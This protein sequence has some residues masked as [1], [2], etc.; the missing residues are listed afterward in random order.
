MKKVLLAVVG[1]VV[2]L[3]V[4]GV[5]FGDDDAPVEVPVE[6]TTVGATPAAADCLP[7]ASTRPVPQ[8]P[9]H[10]TGTLDWPVVPP[11]SGEHHAQTLRITPRFYERDVD[12]PPERAVHDLEHGIV[13]AWYDRELPGDEVEVLRQV[14]D[15]VPT[16]R[17]VVVPWNRAAFAD[18]RHVVL[19]AWGHTQRCRRVS[20]QVF[21]D[22]VRTYADKD[23][24][25]KGAPV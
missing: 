1:V 11:D 4:V 23:A 5:V 24:P 9:P 21:A 3:V 25:E 14:A 8:G 19:T 18:G 7:V 12:P 15:A 17:F 10:R 22:F 13:V 20:G 16:N 6:L 2:V